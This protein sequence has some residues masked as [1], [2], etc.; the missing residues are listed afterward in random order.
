MSVLESVKYVQHLTGH[1]S[2]Q[3]TL[4]RYSHWVPSMRRNTAD[5]IDEAFGT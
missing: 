2:I 4:E 1:A 5:G 3:L